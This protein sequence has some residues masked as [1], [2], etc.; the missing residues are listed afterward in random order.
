MS[1]TLNP[2]APDYANRYSKQMSPEDYA[3]YC[4]K[5]GE[6]ERCQDRANCC[7]EP[8]VP[9]C[10][11]KCADPCGE[12]SYFDLGWLGMLLI[13]FIIFTVLFWLIYYSLNPTFLQSED[14][15]QNTSKILLASIISSLILVLVVWI[16]FSCV[17]Y[18]C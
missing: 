17:K 9:V 18:S 5:R 13:W 1:Q 10:E 4:K 15:Q 14:G 7:N 8:V 16:I 2:L 3:R 11:D 12:K 6:I